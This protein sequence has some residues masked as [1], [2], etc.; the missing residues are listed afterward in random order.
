MDT[1][2]ASNVK[3]GHV[4]VQEQAFSPLGVNF[5]FYANY[6][7]K[8]SF[9][10]CTNIAAM[11]TTCCWRQSQYPQQFDILS[12]YL[13]IDLF[14]YFVKLESSLDGHHHL[15]VYLVILRQREQLSKSFVQPLGKQPRC[16]LLGSPSHLHGIFFRC[17]VFA[18]TRRHWNIKVR[19]FMR[20]L[21]R[22]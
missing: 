22:A 9:V 6:V 4:G 15:F 16:G 14:I 20:S 11:Q 21:S 5:Q 19:Y 7:N 8:F 1:S 18:T 2:R 10:L 17:G 3:G 13:F 12:I